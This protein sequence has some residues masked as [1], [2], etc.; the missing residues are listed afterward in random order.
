MK[1]FEKIKDIDGDRIVNEC[2]ELIY[3]VGYE[4]TQLCLQYSDTVSWYE[5]VDHYGKTRIE[6]ECIHFHPE[7]EGSYI[8]TVL[9]DLDFPVASARLPQGLL[10]WPPHLVR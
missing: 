8:K 10:C 3:R 1:I 5:D 9:T 6:H 4:N 2:L 7:L